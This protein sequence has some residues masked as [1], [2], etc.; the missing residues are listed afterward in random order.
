[1]VLSNVRVSTV[2]RPS[3]LVL[4]IKVPSQLQTGRTSVY[5]QRHASIEQ[6]DFLSVGQSGKPA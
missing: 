1:V 3:T 2:S 5:T 4:Y 6:L